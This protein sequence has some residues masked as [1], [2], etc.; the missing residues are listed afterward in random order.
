ALFVLTPASLISLDR[1]TVDLSFT[2]LCIGFALYVRL[3]QDAKAYTVLV[4]A[5]LSRDTGFVLAC[6]ACLALCLERRFAKAAILA[7]AA[8]PATAW[9]LFVNLRTPNYSNE[10]FA[11]LIPFKG[12][13]EALLHPIQYGLGGTV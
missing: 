8:I 9:Y 13:Y 7:T 1:L 4:L 11:E 2:A 5:C 10:K 12:I 6:A 3:K